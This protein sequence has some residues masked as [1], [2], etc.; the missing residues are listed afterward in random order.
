MEAGSISKWNVGEGE[1]F[2]AGDSLAEIETDKATMDFEA[3]DDGVVAR[4]L[5]QA[6]GGEVTVGE[7]IMVTVEEEE[8]VAAFKDFV[9]PAAD[10]PAAEEKVVEEVKPVEVAPP[11]PAPV[12]AAPAAPVAPPTP[13][14]V[15][16]AVP[17]P[18]AVV[19][20]ASDADAVESSVSPAWGNF[21]K[22]KSPL[23]STLSASQKKYIEMYG[24]T[25]QVPI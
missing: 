2:A 16:A 12:V 21:A 25:G 5:V 18:V 23:A 20:A 6:G 24:S 1:A 7:P 22:V 19:A 8:D 14:P 9:A 13:A 3:Q 4:I 15:V 10:T 11:T 17:E